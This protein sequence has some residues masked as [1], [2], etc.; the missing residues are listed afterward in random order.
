MESDS[1]RAEVRRLGI[2]RDTQ[3]SQDVVKRK[4]ELKSMLEEL[5]HGVHI[6]RGRMGP[7]NTSGVTEEK[8]I[9]EEA[10]LHEFAEAS[11]AR[12]WE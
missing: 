7:I 1:L 4:A 8:V 12:P 5:G 9:L 10:R 2:S 6:T 3:E 11:S